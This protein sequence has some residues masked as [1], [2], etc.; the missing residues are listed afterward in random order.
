MH[1]NIWTESSPDAVGAVCAAS[2][3]PIVRTD[4]RK[5]SVIT[6]LN[7]SHTSTCVV[8]SMTRK[9]PAWTAE[10]PLETKFYCTGIFSGSP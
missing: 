5:H 6:L 7:F 9:A 10:E 1:R 3:N 4:N 2:S 8:Q